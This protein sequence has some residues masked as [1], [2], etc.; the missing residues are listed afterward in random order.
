MARNNQE[1]TTIVTLNAKQAKE[2]LKK[3]QDTIDRLK[4]K[5]DALMKDPNSSASDLN[6]TNKALR[7]AE[8]LEKI[9]SQH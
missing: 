1:F 2:E 4:A 5:K 3:M 7:E 6:K 8:E 9:R